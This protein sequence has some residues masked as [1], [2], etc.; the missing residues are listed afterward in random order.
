[1]LKI[2]K[3]VNK[4]TIMKHLY[5]F[6]LAGF[7]IQFAASAQTSAFCDTSANVIIYSNYDG[8][9][10]NIDVDKN[11]PNLKI[12]I[13][14]YEAVKVAISGVYAGNV[15]EVRY[16]GFNGTNDNCSQG[17][18]NTSISGVSA[19]LDT[20]ILYPAAGYSNA[21]GWPNIICNYSCSSTTN[22]G[23][24]NTPD[25]IVYYFTSAFGGTLNYHHT[26][27]SCWTSTSTYSV[28]AGGNC[29]ILPSS[30]IAHKPEADLQV[31][32]NPAVNQLHVLFVDPGC[33]H[34]VDLI[35]LMGEMINSI[36]V[37]G[38]MAKSMIDLR[39]VAPGAYILRVTEGSKTYYKKVTV[40]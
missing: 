30:G 17:V 36:V 9:T 4:I 8:G 28:S 16:A 3:F 19:N 10:L 37:P 29:C 14:T 38:G 25:Q 7:L 18:T 33:L 27:Y 39:G 40:G 34:R 6:L 13:T 22:Q 1:M 35:N 5:S 26:Q 11:I 23:G 2:V 20:I 12:G 15:T 24:C 21:N 32:P 31:F